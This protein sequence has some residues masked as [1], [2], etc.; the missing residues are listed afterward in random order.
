M[1]SLAAAAIEESERDFNF[2]VFQQISL[3]APY[4]WG[5]FYQHFMFNFC[6]NILLPK[7]Y[8]AKQ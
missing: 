4:T 3:A 2:T 1:T 5:Q 7:S 6:A 8:K